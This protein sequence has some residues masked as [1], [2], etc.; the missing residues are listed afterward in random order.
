MMEYNSLAR[1]YNILDNYTTLKNLAQAYF[2]G[3]SFDGYSKRDLHHYINQELLKNYEGEETLK[4]A[5]T[6]YF[7]AKNVIAA[8]EVSLL[9]S[10]ADF[11]A[12]NGDSKSF[13]IKSNLDSLVRIEKQAND[14]SK[15][16]E[17]NY[18][19]VGERHLH[20]IKDILPDHYGIWMLNNRNSI[21]K[22]SNASISP[23]LDE[24]EQLK[25]FTKK[26]LRKNFN[27]VDI[28]KILKENSAFEINL[29]LKKVLKMRYQ[30]RWN[31]LITNY[32][33]ILP[34]NMQF[35]FSKNLNPSV[36]Y[37]SN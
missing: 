19:V 15:I 32:D 5:L 3:S 17:Y 8:F 9:G 4:F 20:K 30:K 24:F 27:T 12:I 14:Y 29:I 22:F 2:L 34:M 35:F 36:I 31:F 6:R 23:Y 25:L 18:V 33:E 11:I 13:E 37:D 1:S 28:P 7:K 26:E 21:K 10:R 16:F